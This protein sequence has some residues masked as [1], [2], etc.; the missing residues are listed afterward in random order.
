MASLCACWCLAA[1]VTLRAL[2]RGR[3]AP[4]PAPLL[5]IQLGRRPRGAFFLSRCQMGAD[6]HLEPEPEPELEQPSVVDIFSKDL[7]KAREDYISKLSKLGVHVPPDMFRK[8]KDEILEHL[9][10]IR[11]SKPD[12]LRYKKR[13]V[14]MGEVGR[15]N[16]NTDEISKI[17]SAL[18]LASTVMDMPSLGLG[19]NEISEQTYTRRARFFGASEI[20]PH[21]SARDASHKGVQMDTICSFLGA[22]RCLGAIAH[23]LVQD[24]VANLEDTHFKRKVT[25]QLDTDYHQF[26][27]KMKFLNEELKMD[28]RTEIV[29]QIL[30]EGLIHA[31]RYISK[32]IKDASSPRPR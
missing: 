26:T 4:T 9:W 2:P 3:C 23:I 31:K 22:F 17:V 8:Q 6:S 20:A 1:P 18:N 11:R 32:L 24:T 7:E 30:L 12:T 19:T 14:G 25:H 13:R 10:K 27:K 16:A 15:D 21:H 29:D 5:T 28:N